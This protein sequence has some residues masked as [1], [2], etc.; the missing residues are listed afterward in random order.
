MNIIT[1]DK[2]RLLY[3]SDNEFIDDTI[4]PTTVPKNQKKQKEASIIASSQTSDLK[5]LDV[6]PV[7]RLDAREKRL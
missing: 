2:N 1:K 7:P 3:N 5:I 4:E 6:T